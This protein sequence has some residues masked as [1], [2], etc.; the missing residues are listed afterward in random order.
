MEIK[1]SA[2]FEHSPLSYGGYMY[3]K[4]TAKEKQEYFECRLALYLDYG[5]DEDIAIEFA[6]EDLEERLSLEI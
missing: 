2:G 5:E 6:K 3:P 1:P 4:M